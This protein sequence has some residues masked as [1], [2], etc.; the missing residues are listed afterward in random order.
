MMLTSL[1]YT[2]HSTNWHIRRDCKRNFKKTLQANTVMPDSQQYPSAL[3]DQV[4]MFIIL[5]FEL[6]YFDCGFSTK[7]TCLNYHPYFRFKLQGNP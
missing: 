7:L 5:N 1:M 3:F 4:S 2:L 6:I